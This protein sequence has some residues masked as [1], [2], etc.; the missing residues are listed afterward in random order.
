MSPTLRIPISVAARKGVSAVAA[1]A[2]DQRV[3]LT[4]HGRTVA[5]VDSAERIDADL[6]V[7]REAALAVL[8]AAANLVSDR[9]RKFSLDEVCA[10]L[11]VDPDVVRRRS[12]ERANG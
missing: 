9:S 6:R 7:V 11:G 1:S 10:R 4:N 3:L 2:G 8:D 5:V 12:G